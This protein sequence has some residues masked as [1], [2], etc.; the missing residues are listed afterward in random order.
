VRADY[1]KD[2]HSYLKY[3][4][5][6]VFPGIACSDKDKHVIEDFQEMYKGQEVMHPT[7]CCQVLSLFFLDQVVKSWCASQRLW[8]SAYLFDSSNSCHLF[9]L[10]HFNVHI[11]W[12]GVRSYELYQRDANL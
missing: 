2:L 3:C 7:C 11:L 8:I 12:P 4:K 10:L 6:V 9:F 1:S 5:D